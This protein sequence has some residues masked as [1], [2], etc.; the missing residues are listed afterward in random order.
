MKDSIDRLIQLIKEAH[1]SLTSFLIKRAIGQF[2]DW[3]Y[4]T[5]YQAVD[6]AVIK[7]D[8]ILLGQKKKD[9]E[10]WRFIGGFSDVDSPSLEEDAIREVI[11]EASI[12]VVNPRYLGSCLVD[13]DRYKNSRHCIKTAI[14]I[15]NYFSGIPVAGDDIDAVK[16]FDIKKL[17]REEIIEDHRNVLDI[18]NEN[19]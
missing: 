2:I 12:T 11:E 3:V 13:D 10:L 15:A 14:F 17:K 18:V 6:I 7:G 9:G 1:G 16:W 5:A 8:K 4:P 19:L